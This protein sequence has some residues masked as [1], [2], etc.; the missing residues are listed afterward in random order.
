MKIGII[1]ANG[2]SGSAI[3]KEA[4]TRGFSTTAIVRRKEGLP[5]DTTFLIKDVFE[6]T[7]ADLQ[8]FD[9]VVDA[10]GFWTDLEKH[11]TSTKHLLAISQG[12]KT[13]LFFVG[14]AGSL[15]VNPEHSLTLEETPDFPVAFKPLASAMK[16]ALDLIKESHDV[17][18]TYLSPAADFQAD[19]IRTG[20]YQ[21]AGEELTVNDS[22]ESV[23]SYADYAI[24]LVDEIAEP[25]HLNERF[26]VYR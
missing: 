5:E 9:V 24:A 8:D 22:G 21:L 25:T 7:A 14:G 19:G 3:L 18:W 11:V 20:T 2:K 23:I 10:L 4:Q 17:Q 15:F 16:E 13:R 1:G 26:S 6:L 12:L